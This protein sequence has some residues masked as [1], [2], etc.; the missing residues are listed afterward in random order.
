[1]SYVDQYHY[2]STMVGIVKACR[3]ELVAALPIYAT[4]HLSAA[5]SVVK[6][7]VTGARWRIVQLVE[8]QGLS[9]P[10][11]L[12]GFEAHRRLIGSNLPMLVVDRE[13]ALVSLI[14]G[15][16]ERSAVLLRG[17]DAAVEL[18][19]EF[20]R[21]W[22]AS[23]PVD[24]PVGT[25][26]RTAILAGLA[27]GQTDSAIAAALQMGERTVRR[28]INALMSKTGA[29]SRFQLGMHTAALGMV[30]PFESPGTWVVAR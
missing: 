25:D 4:R 22:V 3:A 13:I 7:H 2:M 29:R 15:R 23:T 10:G 16:P 11:R 26:R 24:E 6:P 30:Q 8:P 17:G 9:R 19:E 12:P 20:E 1:V 21:V 5:M 18:V 27:D 28:E 14:V